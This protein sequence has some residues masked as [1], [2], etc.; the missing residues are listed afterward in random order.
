VRMATGNYERALKSISE[1]QEIIINATGT[2]S[3]LST[4]L[5]LKYSETKISAMAAVHSTNAGSLIENLLTKGRAIG[6]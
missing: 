2:G 4:K 1:V 3:V 5:L 6:L